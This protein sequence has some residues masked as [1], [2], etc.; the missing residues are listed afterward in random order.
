MLYVGLS[1]DGEP[2]ILHSKWGLKT[3]YANPELAEHLSRY[4]IEGLHQAEDGSIYGRYII[5]ETLITSVNLG[6]GNPEI[7]TPLIEDIYVMTTL[8]QP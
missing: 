1:D 6:S 8:L 3:T 2:L 5:G 4:P 7:T